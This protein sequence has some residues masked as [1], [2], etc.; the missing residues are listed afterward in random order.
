MNLKGILNFIDSK[1]SI[2]FDVKPIEAINYFKNKGLKT[3]FSYTDMLSADH[4]NNFT[5]AKMMDMDLLQDMYD[6]LQ[7]AQKKGW[8]LQ[9]WKDRMIPHLQANG[10]WGRQAVVDP[11]TG[12]TIIAELGSSR[13]LDVIFRT[14]IQQAYMAGQWQQIKEQ[15]RIAPY[16]MYNAVDDY[17]TREEHRAWDNKIYPVSHPF[18]ITHMPLNGWNCRC[19]VIQFS[20]SDLEDLG[21]EVSEDIKEEYRDWKNPRTGLIEKIPKGVDGG[22]NVNAG[23]ARFE[24]LQK[25]AKE[26]AHA[27][28]DKALREAAEE[29]LVKIEMQA[30]A[31]GDGGIIEASKNIVEP[32][33][34]PVRTEWGDFPDT[35]I[36]E[37]NEAAFRKHPNYGQAK[38]GNVDDALKLMDDYLTPL[39]INKIEKLAGDK[40]PIITGVQAVEGVSTNVIPEVFASYLAMATNWR[41]DKDIYQQNRVGHTKSSGF[42]RMATPALFGGLVLEGEHYLLLDDFIGQGGTLAN[43]KGYI[44]SKGGIVIGSIVMAGKDFSSKL[45]LQQSTLTELRSKHGNL[46]PEWLTVFGYGFDFLTESEARYLVKTENADRIRAEILA[47][48]KNRNP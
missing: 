17:R 39:E 21:Y 13:R 29:A 1:I 7:Q 48:T 43:M 37:T 36:V 38:S 16:L 20:K 34:K 26:K 45:K 9:Q 6:S 44:E 12:K 14:N 22:F 10:W 3:T 41:L 35:V 5:I 19:T 33:M 32:N 25:I 24:Q 42:H 27:I 2:G 11:V 31:L 47:T 28:K 23:Q 30:K 46:E 15:E 8:T 40:N 4:V 18:W